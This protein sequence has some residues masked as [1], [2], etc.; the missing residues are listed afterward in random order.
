MHFEF[1]AQ[2][3]YIETEQFLEECFSHSITI[4]GTQRLHAFIPIAS[5]TS[6]ILVKSF[7]HAT[8]STIETVTK[9]LGKLDLRD[10]HGYVTVMYDNK[11]WLAYVL[12][13][14]EDLDEVKV[15]FLHPAGPSS[16][17]SYP[18][19]PDILWVSI[20]DVL[21]TVNPVTPTGRMYQ[22]PEDDTVKTY[23]AFKKV[24]S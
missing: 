18:T 12:T 16:Y 2:E 19:K 17:Y 23:E 5:T 15:T 21:C 22:I 6:K 20:N 1:S 14:D 24:K 13:Q 8:E 3:E 7:L 11:W 10:I 4:K 9:S